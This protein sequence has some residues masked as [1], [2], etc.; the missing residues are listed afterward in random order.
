MTISLVQ[1]LCFTVRADN[2]SSKKKV[3]GD[4]FD[5]DIIVDVIQI[6]KV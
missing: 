1:K 2:N 4:Y 5:P 3:D 6:Q